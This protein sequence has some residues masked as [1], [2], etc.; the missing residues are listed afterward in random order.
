M[1]LVELETVKLVDCD[2]ELVERLVD[3]D[4]DC[5]RLVLVDWLVE[6]VETEV[7]LVVEVVVDDEVLVL[8]PVGL[9]PTH[10]RRSGRY[11]SHLIAGS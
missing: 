7:L 9:N 3:C 11:K 5:V 2:V 1:T 6:L 8:G 10:I 4:V